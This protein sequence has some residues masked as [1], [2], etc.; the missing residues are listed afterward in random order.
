MSLVKQNRIIDYDLSKYNTANVVFKPQ[1]M[2][3]QEL[4]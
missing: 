3:P 1:N 2:S 4:I